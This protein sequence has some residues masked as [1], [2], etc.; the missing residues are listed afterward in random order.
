[1]NKGIPTWDT[2]SPAVFFVIPAHLSLPAEPFILIGTFLFGLLRLRL[3]CC[4]RLK[5]QV[6]SV[7]QKQVYFSPVHPDFIQSVYNDNRRKKSLYWGWFSWPLDAWMWGDRAVNISTVFGEVII[8]AEL[9][10]HWVEHK[11]CF[12]VIMPARGIR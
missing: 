10:W 7:F 3:P 2:Q 1:M 8:Y 6:L 9:G 12:R 4:F 11:L 5:T